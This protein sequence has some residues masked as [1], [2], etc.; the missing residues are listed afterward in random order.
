MENRIIES[1]G[2]G[3]VCVERGGGS[4]IRYYIVPIYIH[5]YVYI[6]I[7]TYSWKISLKVT[8]RLYDGP[9]F[10]AHRRG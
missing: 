10:T 9:G 3:G 1:V 2:G 8:W 6:R 5:I 4:L 7:H